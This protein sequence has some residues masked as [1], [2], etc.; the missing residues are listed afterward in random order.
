MSPFA[1]G[2]S[3]VNLVGDQGEYVEPATQLNAIH[4]GLVGISDDTRLVRVYNWVDRVFRRLR[5]EGSCRNRFWRFP[6]T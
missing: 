6:K 1:M 2:S 4:F 3:M 5:T